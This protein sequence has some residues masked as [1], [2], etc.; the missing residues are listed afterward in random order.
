[1]AKKKK[2]PKPMPINGIES[3]GPD[4]SAFYQCQAPSCSAEFR[5]TNEPDRPDDYPHRVV[6]WCPFCGNDDLVK[7]CD[8]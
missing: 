4:Q 8:D 5:L 7:I 6:F 2:P 3:L 1:M